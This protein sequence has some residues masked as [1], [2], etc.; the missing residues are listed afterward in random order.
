MP[1]LFSTLRI[2]DVRSLLL[3]SV[4]VTLCI[5]EGVGLQL[6]PIP[7][8]T[9]VHTCVEESPLSKIRTDVP[10]PP[11]QSKSISCRVEIIVLKLKDL[12]H[13]QSIQIIASALPAAQHFNIS[14]SAP[15]YSQ[16]RVSGYS[17]TFV[18]QGA[19]RAP[20]LPA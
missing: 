10:G 3:I 15:V 5:S 16:E 19:S 4:L 1:T 12:P 6:L 8:A 2:F 18:L 9:E 14:L 17:F 7:N 13:Q 11:P 20:P